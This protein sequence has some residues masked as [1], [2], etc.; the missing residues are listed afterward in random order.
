[1]KIREVMEEYHVSRKALLVYEEKG[2][3]HPERDDFGYRQYSDQDIEYLEKIV[4]LRKLDFSLDDIYHL[5]ILHQDD[6][7]HDKK[8]EYEKDIYLMERRRE[9]LDYIEEVLHGKYDIHEAIEALDDSFHTYGISKEKKTYFYL[10]IVICLMSLLIWI[11]FLFKEDQVFNC[12]IGTA[13]L[14]VCFLMMSSF[15]KV[16][17]LFSQY[18]KLCST[19]LVSVGFFIL[20]FSLRYEYDGVLGMSL[21]QLSFLFII[22]GSIYNS[23]I[24]DFILKILCL[25]ES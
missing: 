23:W 5:L 12:A 15:S 14:S 1:M 25:S 11:V 9:Y 17:Y 19:I 22:I 18:Q 16:Q 8:K 24:K 13:S 20:G 4:L 3:L 21:V 7:L 6:L 10:K 2:L